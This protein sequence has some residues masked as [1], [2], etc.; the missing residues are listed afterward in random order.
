[1][2]EPLDRP[3]SARRGNDEIADGEFF[4]CDFAAIGEDP[5]V[6][7][8][9][10]E[11]RNRRAGDIERRRRAGGEAEVIED[12]GAAARRNGKGQGVGGRVVGV[13]ISS[14]SE[15][16]HPERNRIAQPKV[17]D[18]KGPAVLKVVL[19]RDL[20]VAAAVALEIEGVTGTKIRVGSEIDCPTE[21]IESADAVEPR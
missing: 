1:M 18:G 12:I 20:Q 3:R 21:E 14:R 19:A 8:K 4:D 17:G 5:G 10:C 16:A 11:I 7:G 9:A 6:G 13:R 15:E 2:A